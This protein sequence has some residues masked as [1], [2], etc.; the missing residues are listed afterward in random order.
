MLNNNLAGFIDQNYQPAVGNHAKRK[1]L[2]ERFGF[3]IAQAN[4]ENVLQQIFGQMQL[5]PIILSQ[6]MEYAK[7]QTPAGMNTQANAYQAGRMNQGI[8]A[9]QN[10]AAR[11]QAAG[12]SGSGSAGA[13]RDQANQATRDSNA[14]RYQQQDPNNLLRFIQALQQG[15]Q[16]TALPA[17]QMG[18][19]S[20]FNRPGGEEKQGGGF[21]DTV[22]SIVGMGT[23]LGM[24]W[25]KVFSKGGGGTVNLGGLGL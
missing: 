22:S 21:L 14:F 12:V 20:V 17:S 8:E 13:I 16:I 1:G 2:A 3:G 7:M 24:D 9:G 18:I 5:N 19:G 23:G 11:Y 4:Q 6:L 25:G 15:G 10:M